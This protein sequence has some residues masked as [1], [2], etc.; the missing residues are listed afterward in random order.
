MSERPITQPFSVTL[1]YP[2]EDKTETYSTHVSAYTAEGA[3]RAAQKRASG[4]NDGD[5]EP[6]A[7]EPVFVCHGLVENVMP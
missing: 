5:I 1:L 4:A 6:E 2:T 7:F 3:I